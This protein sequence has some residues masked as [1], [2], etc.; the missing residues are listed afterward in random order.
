MTYDFA[1]EISGRTAERPSRW[2]ARL[3]YCALFLVCAGGAYAG[4]TI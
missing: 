1:D 2:T 3:L 4:M